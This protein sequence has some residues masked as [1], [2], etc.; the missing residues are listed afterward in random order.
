MLN[1]F[2]E[3]EALNKMKKIKTSEQQKHHID[4][5]T[6]REKEKEREFTC[7][8]TALQHI[9]RERERGLRAYPLSK[10]CSV[11]HFKLGW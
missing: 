9:E 6:V 7:I 8:T 10:L 4:T 2:D 5:Y 1:C 11:T 3:S